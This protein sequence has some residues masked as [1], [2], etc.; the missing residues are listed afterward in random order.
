MKK[1]LL[2][3]AAITVVIVGVAAA[4]PFI[5][6][7]DIRGAIEEGD[8]ERLSD[9]VDFP[10][11][12]TSLKEQ[13]NALIMKDAASELQG[14][15]F[16]ALG[17]AFASKLV[18]GMVDSFVTPAGL[19]NVMAGHK[20]QQDQGAA[21]Q[22]SSARAQPF[23][24]AR[25]TYDGLSK[26]SAWVRDEKGEEVRFV[27]TRNLWTWRLS[28]ILV[29]TTFFERG[30]SASPRLSGTA[31][32]VEPATPKEPEAFNVMLRRKAFRKADYMA[33]I[34]DAITIAVTFTNVSGQDIRA[35]DGVLE[36]TD[37]LDNEILSAKVAINER[38]AAQS[39]LDWNGEIAYNQFMDSHQKLRNENLENMKVTFRTRKILFA[40]GTTKEFR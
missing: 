35:F 12:R 37:L 20:P 11:L 14:N 6:I 40:D 39:S 3:A 15:P 31:K 21:S 9:R 1:A 33:G 28:N 29:P 17:M 24:N 23:Q 8:S 34:Q 32:S 4:G 22:D 27:F 16:A 25:Y 36:F 5:A 26:F 18:D 30:S 10:A 2:L 7:H 19:G 13:F 38:V